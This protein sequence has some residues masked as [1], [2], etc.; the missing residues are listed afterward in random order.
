[1]KNEP[2]EKMVAFSSG[3]K[4][5]NDLHRDAFFQLQGNLFIKDEINYESFMQNPVPV[6]IPKV[7]SYSDFD[8]EREI[9][10]RY[11]DIDMPSKV[12]YSSVKNSL[13]NSPLIKD[14]QDSAFVENIDIDDV[15]KK[16]EHNYQLGE[17]GIATPFKAP[18][19]FRPNKIYEFD[20]RL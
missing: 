14:F 19:R 17:S 13:K 12:K 20:Y 16:S 2:L 11:F 15:I 10:D 8:L 9:I 5:Y 4:I 7:N 18:L 3:Q 6:F 1:V